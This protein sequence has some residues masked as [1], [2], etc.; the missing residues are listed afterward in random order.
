MSLS[1]GSEVLCQVDRIT[2]QKADVTVVSLP[3]AIRGSIRLQDV[4]SF[5]IDKTGIPDSFLPGD[6]VR[7]T[8]ISVGDAKSCFF[9][10]NQ[11]NLGVVMAKDQNGELLTP[12]DESHMRNT[13][14]I[15]F[16]RKVAKPV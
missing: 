12:V 3:G 1:V 7:A 10:T 16:K 14:G 2:L 11:P 8:A 13:A 6:L 5:D 9:A 15:V 4:R